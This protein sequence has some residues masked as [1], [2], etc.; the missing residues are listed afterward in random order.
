VLSVVGHLAPP[1]VPSELW[2]SWNWDP[3]LW[4][5][6]LALLVLHERGWRTG[7]RQRW[8]RW[9]FVAAIV[10]AGI[11]LL[12]PLD[13]LSSTLASAHMV[14]H[15]LLTMVV[16]PLVVVSR[17]TVTL[18]RGLPHGAR[19]DLVRLRRISRVR[20]ADVVRTHPITCAAVHAV[21]LWIWHASGP[22]ELALRNDLVHRLEHVTFLITAVCSW[23]AIILVA[24]RHRGATGTSVLV[25]FGLSVQGSILGAL[26]TFA[27]DPWYPS[28]ATRTA[29]WGLTPLEDQQLAGVIMWVPAG[30]VYLG[31]ALGLM[32]VW[33]SQPPPTR[34]TRPVT[35]EYARG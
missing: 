7:R 8:R 28:Y 19:R 32:I 10:C 29:P 12:S 24:R 2:Q 22:Y 35:S 34:G 18:L 33:I 3:V 27:A 16:A 13:A 5:T 17:P 6:L 26:L 4:S 25:L 14:Q 9:S 11:A 1:L 30:V 20:P 21:T 15:L 31:A 23:A